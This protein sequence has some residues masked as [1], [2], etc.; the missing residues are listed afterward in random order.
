MCGAEGGGGHVM[1]VA[2]CTVRTFLLLTEY[3]IN[4]ISLLLYWYIE[5]NLSTVKSMFES[6]AF[7]KVCAIKNIYSK[8]TKN[9]TISLAKA[10]ERC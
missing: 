6:L 4:Y 1:H 7:I 9:K 5:H 2:F 3:K 10:D 8:N